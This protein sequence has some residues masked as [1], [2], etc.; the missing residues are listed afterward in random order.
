MNGL[1]QT[2]AWRRNRMSRATSSQN[3]VYNYF[4]LYLFIF[5]YWFSVMFVKP[6]IL[7]LPGVHSTQ[8]TFSPCFLFVPWLQLYLLSVSCK[9]KISSR[10]LSANAGGDLKMIIGGARNKLKKKA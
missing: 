2:N 10:A 6:H 8:L 4:T 9:T 3:F 1:L 5:I 7:F